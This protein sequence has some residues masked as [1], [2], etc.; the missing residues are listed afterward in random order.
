MR[1]YKVSHNGGSQLYATSALARAAKK[2]ILEATGDKRSAVTILE[3]DV[4]VT[5]KAALIEY[6]NA[7]LAP[8][9]AL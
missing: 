6:V 3:H 1:C 2:R 8:G 9:G 5:P 7:L 4:P